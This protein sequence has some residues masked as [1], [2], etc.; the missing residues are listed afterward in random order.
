MLNKYDEKDDPFKMKLVF[1]GAPGVGKGT[2]T[3]DLVSELGLVHVSSGDL[4]R[5]NI[6]KGTTLGKKAKEYIDAGQLVPDDVTI[7]MVKER[8]SQSDCKKKGYILDGFPRTVPQAEALEQF[9]K[10]DTVVNFIA[11]KKVIIERI[12]GRVMGEDGKIYHK[13]FLSPPK[14]L[15]VW[16]RDD[17]KPNVVEERLKEYEKKTKPLVDYY[18]RKKMLQ[19]VSVNEN[20]SDDHKLILEKI[21]K[22]ID[23]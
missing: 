22:A 17:D 2:Y 14:G 13:K 10:I 18:R 16:Q 3:K 21:K 19:E 8:L 7:G 20:Y 5:E 23:G 4:F 6:S 1:L 15:K 9:A 11:D 12:S